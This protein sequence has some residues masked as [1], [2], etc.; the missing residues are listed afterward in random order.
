MADRTIRDPGLGTLGSGNH[1][2]EL[3]EIDERLDRRACHGLGLEERPDALYALIHTGSRDVGQW[4]GSIHARW[5]REAWA[6]AGKSAPEGI[7]TLE[8]EEAKAYLAAQWAAARYAWLNRSAL[9]EMA[10]QAIESAL[11]APVG[12]KAIADCSHNVALREGGRIIHRKG[13]C[14][15]CSGETTL[16]PGSMG[17]Y[18]FVGVGLGRPDALASCSHGAGRSKPRGAG[19]KSQGRSKLPFVVETQS[20]RRV[21]EEAPWNYMDVE[22][23]AGALADA[24]LIELAARMRPWATFKA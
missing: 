21:A 8:G 11:G 23:G 16:I 7:F 24:G 4:V 6:K 17:D 15:A 2:F 1:F 9:Q 10:R 20:G 13:A 18:S 22:A 14:R 3:Q 5:A 19:A 12:A